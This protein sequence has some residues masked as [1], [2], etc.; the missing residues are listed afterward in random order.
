MLISMLRSHV[1]A[2]NDGS[3]PDICTTW[4]S[5]SEEHSRKAMELAVS[6]FKKKVEEVLNSDNPL[7]EQT[8]AELYA[9]ESKK[10]FDFYRDR[11]VGDAGVEMEAELKERI[12][13]ISEDA[14]K[15]NN[16]KTK[17]VCNEILEPMINPI[18]EKLEEH[19]YKDFKSF[20]KD[21]NKVE[22]KYIKQTSHLSNVNQY[23]L[24]IKNEIL[25]GSC[26]FFSTLSEK[27]RNERDNE[28]KS[29]TDRIEMDRSTMNGMLALLLGK[30]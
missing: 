26:E 2:I 6:L 3:V 12:D 14:Y 11:S 1:G 24:T 28:L 17:E 30:I 20:K 9:V 21:L 7:N 25:V 5:I 8:L 19:E 16:E 22:E 10:A 15:K 27:D 29:N 23:F 13:R 18:K 4:G